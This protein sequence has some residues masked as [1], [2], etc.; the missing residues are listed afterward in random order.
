ME[1]ILNLSRLFSQSFKPVLI[2]CNW[3][4]AVKI[5]NEYISSMT[6]ISLHGEF[7]N[8]TD[9]KF[10][11]FSIMVEGKEIF[12]VDETQTEIF[13]MELKNVKQ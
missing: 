6:N 10:N 1:A 13:L 4:D 11:F 7:D 9:S 2:F 3:E 5:R 12:F 8:S